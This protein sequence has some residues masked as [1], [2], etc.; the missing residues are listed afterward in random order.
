MTQPTSPSFPH[1]H[2]GRNV[3]Q[4]RS[5]DP[6]GDQPS[7]V[8]CGSPYIPSRFGDR[9]IC[10]LPDEHFPEPAWRRERDRHIQNGVLLVIVFL[11]LCFVAASLWTA[12]YQLGERQN[13]TISVTGFEGSSK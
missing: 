11:A 13:A 9:T 6:S 7:D 3:I 4:L 1:G 2:A 12:A 8:P 10:D 5:S